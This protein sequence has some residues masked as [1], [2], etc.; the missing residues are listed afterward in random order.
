[1]ACAVAVYIRVLRGRLH[2]KHF[3]FFSSEPSSRSAR[4]WNLLV[5]VMAKSFCLSSVFSFVVSK[6][7]CLCSPVS[8]FLAILILSLHTRRVWS[9]PTSA[10]LH[11]RT[12]CRV[13]L[14]LLETAIWSI[15][16]SVIISGDLHLT[17]FSLRCGK[18]VPPITRSFISQKSTKNAPFSLI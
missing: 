9:D 1:M 11:A 18:T 17:L 2:Q 4:A 5:R 15:W 12:S 14:H 10:P 8:L 7:R 3:H 6:R 16:F 13:R